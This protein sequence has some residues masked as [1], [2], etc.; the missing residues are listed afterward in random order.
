[1]QVQCKKLDLSKY[2]QICHKSI[3]KHTKTMRLLG[4][5]VTGTMTKWQTNI[6]SHQLGCWVLSHRFIFLFRT[7]TPTLFRKNVPAGMSGTQPPPPRSRF[8]LYRFDLDL[9]GLYSCYWLLASRIE[10]FPSSHGSSVA[11]SSR[12]SGLKGRNGQ[13][14]T[15]QDYGVGVH[16]ARSMS[17]VTK[18]G[19]KRPKTIGH[20]IHLQAAQQILERFRP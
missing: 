16:S 12:R 6:C 9:Y 7:S 11:T 4:D 13:R 20:L 10:A 8:I 3:Q 18:T 19:C 17:S 14:D 15:R 1:M 2:P 5:G